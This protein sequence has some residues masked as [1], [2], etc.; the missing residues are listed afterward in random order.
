MKTVIMEEMSWTQVKKAMESGFKTVIIPV[1]S[2]E[3]HGPHLPLGT[4]YLR[5]Y[6]IAREVAYKLGKTLVAPTV[7]PALSK[8]HMHFPGTVTLRPETFRMIL[9]DYVCCYVKHGFKNIVFIN[10]HGGNVGELEKFVKENAGKYP[11]VEIVFAAIGGKVA[12]KSAEEENIPRHI[13]GVHSG[14][15]ETSIMLAFYPQ[16]VDMT[17]AEEGFTGEFTS[18]LKTKMNADGMQSVTH[19]GIL[20][21]SREANAARGI[22]DNMRWVDYCCEYILERLNVG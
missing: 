10:T 11:G 9:E 2:I 19:N 14:H 17:V 21:D 13:S 4:D 12:V 7:R 22:R 8:H 16:F 20:G 18:E 1:G 5:G 15:M 6:P 3:Q